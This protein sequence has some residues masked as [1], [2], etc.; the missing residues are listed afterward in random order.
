MLTSTEIN[1]LMALIGSLLVIATSYWLGGWIFKTGR[2]KNI[3]SVRWWLFRMIAINGL[4]AFGFWMCLF[5][6]FKELASDHPEKMAEVWRSSLVIGGMVFAWLT[7]TMAM[8]LV[9][10][11]PAIRKTMK[12]KEGGANES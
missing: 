7:F 9:I 11:I 10:I 5:F 4:I 1:V 12:E 3:T 2:K 6:V 8:T